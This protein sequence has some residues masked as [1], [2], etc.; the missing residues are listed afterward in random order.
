MI[1]YIVKTTR[2]SCYHHSRK[3]D[4]AGVIID[5]NSSDEV[6]GVEILDVKEVEYFEDNGEAIILKQI[7]EEDG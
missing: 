4:F 5:Y 6:I 2:D 1:A 3:L 7:G